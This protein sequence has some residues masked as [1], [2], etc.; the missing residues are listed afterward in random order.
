MSKIYEAM[1]L[2]KDDEGSDFSPLDEAPI[3]ELAQE[4]PSIKE[5]HRLIQGLSSSSGAF[6]VVLII[7]SVEGEGASTVA[8]NV[9]K[10]LSQKGPILLLDANLRSPSQ[11][12][13][14]G[15]EI[16]P[17][18]NDVANQNTDLEKAV[19]NG[20]TPG[21]SLMTSGELRDDPPLLS[22]GALVEAMDALRSRFDWIIIDGPPAT[23][24]PEVVS[25][26]G[27]ADC[28]VLVVQAERTRWEVADQARRILEE[29]GL[30]I[31][32]AVLNRRKFHIP[33]SLYKRI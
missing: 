5:Y 1:K 29:S 12:V 21:L 16:S 25:L 11:H 28:A 14:F 3:A 6:Q 23:V 18:F 26:A 10:M 27:L 15:V 20:F 9:A 30:H 22:S 2:S 4:I 32:G 8:R 7:S 17:G 19:R 13:A 24:Y 31:L 33:N